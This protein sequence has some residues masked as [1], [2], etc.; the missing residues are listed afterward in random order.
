MYGN[1]SRPFDPSGLAVTIVPIAILALSE[2]SSLLGFEAKSC[3]RAGF[4]TFQADLLTGVL[5]E[6]VRP[7]VDTNQRLLDL[8]QQLA[9]PVS[10]S[11]LEAEF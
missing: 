11:Q 3:H 2:F 8:A 6:S 7:F 5:A 4:E 1:G 9:L 10:R